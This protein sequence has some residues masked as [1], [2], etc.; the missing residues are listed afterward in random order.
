MMSGL[1]GGNHGV[2]VFVTIGCVAL[3]LAIGGIA[4][5][6]LM[7]DEVW[8][9]TTAAQ[10]PSGA[11][12]IVYV[13]D[14]PPRALSEFSFWN[15]SASPGG[16]MVGTPNNGDIL[17]PPPENDPH[18]TFDVQVQQGVPYRCW[19][20]MKVGP[21]KGPAKANRV[22][23]QFT[24]AVDKSGKEILR[25]R[26]GDYLTAQGPETQGW[27]WVGCNAPSGDSLIYFKTAGTS[28]VRIQ[29]G[30]EGVGFDQVVLSPGRFLQ[31][32]PTESVVKK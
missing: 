19:I 23:V 14:L 4:L 31:K 8:S 30:M 9:V 1:R 21:P 5:S 22:F 3:G 16:R 11:D 15:D 6:M 27:T 7:A 28:T 24:N 17:D 12:V 25:P 2:G 29:G 26:T 32:P 10:A 18:V 13:N 20:H